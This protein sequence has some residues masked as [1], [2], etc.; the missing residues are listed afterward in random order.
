MYNP[1]DFSSVLRANKLVEGKYHKM[2]Y[3]NLTSL[4]SLLAKYMSFSFGKNIPIPSIIVIHVPNKGLKDWRTIYENVAGFAD[5]FGVQRIVANATEHQVTRKAVFSTRSVSLA[6][7]AVQFRICETSDYYYS[8]ERNG[9]SHDERQVASSTLDLSFK[10]GRRQLE[11]PFFR[12]EKFIM[13][14]VRSRPRQ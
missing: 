9:Y 14:C 7:D 13:G 8:A 2:P 3:T 5:A 11:P 10:I 12:R 4:K 6:K 1:N